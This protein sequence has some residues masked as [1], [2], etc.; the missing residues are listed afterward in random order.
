MFSSI[1]CNGKFMQDRLFVVKLWCKQLSAAGRNPRVGVV[2][3][4]FLKKEKK[5]NEQNILVKA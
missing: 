4:Y 2:F 5:K 1:G 3:P